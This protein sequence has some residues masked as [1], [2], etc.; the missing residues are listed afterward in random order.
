[1][2]D[3]TID[4][5]GADL[6]SSLWNIGDKITLIS[7]TGNA[8][9]SGFAGFDDNSS[10]TF[11]DN[12]WLFLYADTIPGNNFGTEATG[13]HFVTMTVIPEPGAAM[14]GGIGLLVWLRRRR[15]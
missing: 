7:H 11:G 5:T 4:L 1:L 8:I 15:R 14:L 13:D 12:E 10:H 3:V 9:S 2:N 6:A